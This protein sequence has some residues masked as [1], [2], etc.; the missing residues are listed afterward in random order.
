M[1]RFYWGMGLF[2]WVFLLLIVH[3]QQLVG[4]FAGGFLQI[5]ALE[6]RLFVEEFLRV[7]ILKYP[8]FAEGF[9]HPA[10]VCPQ[11]G[12][13]FPLPNEEFP[14]LAEGFLPLGGD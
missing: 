9:L 2:A 1:G 11:L 3:F 5:F 4:D 10:E 12:E 7:F 6:Y 14:A 8:Q 13:E